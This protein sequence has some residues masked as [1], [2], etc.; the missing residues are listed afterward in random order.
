MVWV[1]LAFLAI[2]AYKDVLDIPVELK[3]T[4]VTH[5][6][7]IASVFKLV[8][9]S[10]DDEFYKE[11]N[12]KVNIDSDNLAIFTAFYLGISIVWT[13]TSAVLLYCKFDVRFGYIEV[14]FVFVVVARFSNE[15]GVYVCSL[16][17]SGI[18][19]IVTVVDLTLMSLLMA[20]Y[21]TVYDYASQTGVTYT[22]LSYWLLV[23]GIMFTLAGRGYVLLLVNIGSAI[24][25]A[26]FYF[27][28]KSKITTERDRAILY[29]IPIDAYKEHPGYV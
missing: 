4:N 22:V 8:Y 10:E 19:T 23:I 16:G 6:E 25:F 3:V 12:V 7:Y 29:N 20:D 24:Y 11:V 14:I 21:S 15:V 5:D 27:I 13:I 9:F 2:L 18:V 1:I 17:Y 28:K 26:S